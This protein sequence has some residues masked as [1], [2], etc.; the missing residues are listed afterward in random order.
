MDLRLFKYFVRVA[1]LQSF[2][3]AA[4]DLGVTQP[5]L[6][7]QI[8]MLEEYVGV[9]LFTR[10]SR[11]VRL[12]PAGDRML[13]HAKQ[14]LGYVESAIEDVR[15]ADVHD[16]GT[17]RV[18]CSGNHILVQVLAVYSSQHPNV[19]VLVYDQRSQQTIEGVLS[20]SLDIG[21]IFYTHEDSRLEFRPLFEEEFYVVVR[22]DSPIVECESLSVFDLPELPLVLF[23]SHFLIRRFIDE[24]CAA[25]GVTLHPKLQLSS[26]ESQRELLEHGNVATILTKSYLNLINDPSLR[27]IRVKEGHPR[28]WVALVH[29]KNAQ[30]TYIQRD[31]IELALKTLRSPQ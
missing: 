8:Q 14:I 18:G 23:P 25:Y 21:V 13:E 31:F 6:S 30:L 22:Q 20:G 11:S 7:K 12:T 17:L 3:K 5:T 26:L 10:S 2:T 27:A 15:L 28:R 1:E 24:F 16:K 29:P 19:E 4:E 9:A